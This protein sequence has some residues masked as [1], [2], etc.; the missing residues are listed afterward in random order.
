MWELRDS[1]PSCLWVAVHVNSQR[2]PQHWSAS[3]VRGARAGQVS[4]RPRPLVGPQ[5]AGS[6]PPP[7][8]PLPSGPLGGEPSAGRSGCGRSYQQRLAPPAPER[9]GGR[10]TAWFPLPGPARGAASLQA[11]PAT[12]ASANSWSVSADSEFARF[13]W[14]G[15]A[16]PHC[17]LTPPGLFRF[18]AKYFP[19]NSLG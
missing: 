8:T 6:A 10:G 15:R 11:R 12:P 7:P 5:T 13:S 4:R 17:S 18:L 3:L 19:Q 14:R 9:R 1:P 2:G 16:L